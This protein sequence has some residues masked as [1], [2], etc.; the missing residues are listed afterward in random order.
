MGGARGSGEGR[1]VHAE[2]SR[3]LTS[4]KA[5]G[6]RTG[7]DCT[8]GATGTFMGIGAHDG[9]VGVSTGTKAAL[10]K[11]TGGWRGVSGEA[12]R[13]LAGG[14]GAGEGAGASQVPHEVWFCP[15]VALQSVDHSVA[16]K[17]RVGVT[18]AAIW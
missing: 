8:A 5:E 16:P 12:L 6:A 13:V 4:T 10:G 7:G 11:A 9:D 17:G 2:E 3:P 18:V 1:T 14:V 15:G